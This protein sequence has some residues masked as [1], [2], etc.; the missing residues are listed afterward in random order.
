MRGDRAGGTIRWRMHMD[1]RPE[2]VFDALDSDE[3][4]RSF[5]AESAEEREGH[6]HFRFINGMTHT[7]R[8]LSR[9]PPRQWAIEYFGCVARFELSPDGRG[10]TDLL[11]T[12]DGVDT[13]DWAEMHAGWLN[14]LFP[15]KG[16]LV[17]GVDLRNHDPS[18]TWDDGYADQ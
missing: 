3:G 1:A 10:G 13:E 14:V 15:L 8:I 16:Y 11:L 9:Q 18:R 7:S 2:S 5:W 6:I 12:C 4:R 17:H